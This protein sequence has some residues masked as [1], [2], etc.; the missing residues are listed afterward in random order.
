MHLHITTKF[1]KLQTTGLWRCA[2]TP[3][4]LQEPSVWR[5]ACS[6]KYASCHGR[7]G[8]LGTLAVLN[9][10]RVI[11][12]SSAHASTGYLGNHLFISRSARLASWQYR[13]CY[14]HRTKECER[15]CRNRGCPPGFLMPDNASTVLKR[16]SACLMGGTTLSDQQLPVCWKRVALNFCYNFAPG[17]ITISNRTGKIGIHQHWSAECMAR[18]LANKQQHRNRGPLMLWRDCSLYQFVPH[19]LTC[20]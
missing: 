16:R 6:H 9:V 13:D 19:C 8:K 12:K 11:P 14:S 3:F 2:K 15:R 4:C 7:K 5:K 10:A 1:V 17:G 18:K 20:P